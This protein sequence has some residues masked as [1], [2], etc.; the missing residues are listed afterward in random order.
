MKRAEGAIRLFNPRLLPLFAAYLIL[1]IFCVKFSYWVAAIIEIVAIL[2]ILLLFRTKSVGRALAIALFAVFLF[3]YGSA[4]LSLCLRN[5]VGAAGYVSATCRVVE[6]E[7]REDEETS[8]VT[9]VVKADRLRADGRMRT[10]GVSFETTEAVEVGDRLTLKGT[11]SIKELSLKNAFTALEYRRGEKYRMT[12]T[13]LAREEGRAPL[14][15]RIKERTRELFCKTQGERAGAFSYAMLFGDAE[16]MESE[17]RS[18]M[19]A[20]GVAHV[21]AVSGLHVGVLSAALLFLLRK[22]RVKDKYAFFLLLPIFGFY[23]YLV[24]FTPSVIRAS[25]MVLLGV[26][27]SALGER[28]DGISALSFSAILILVVRPLYLFD[29]SFVMSFLAILGIQSL[30][31]PLSRLFRG[32]RVPWRVAQP[33]ALSVSVTLA[34]LPVTAVVFGRFSPLG[35]LLNLAVVPLASLAYVLNLVCLPFAALLPTFGAALEAVGYLPLVISEISLW[36]AGLGVTVSYLFSA[37]EIGVYYAVLLFVG[38]YSLARRPVKLVA[39]G[40]AAGVLLILLLA[41]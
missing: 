18:S 2:S 28:Y 20:V 9:Y 25:L 8:L 19:R 5:E 34:L 17:D 41:A 30:N 12:V 7:T 13:S 36:A 15:Y 24:G 38:K 6:V 35:A 40:I 39:G 31:D 32:W 27:A 23:A 21:F 10:G 26:G 37:T 29:V 1:G 3:G 22:L 11:I 33:L 4:S 16:Y 14:S